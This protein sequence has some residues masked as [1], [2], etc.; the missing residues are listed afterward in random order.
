[1]LICY[2]T[3]PFELLLMTYVIFPAMVDNLINKTLSWEDEKKSHFLYDGVS[4]DVPYN[5]SGCV[6][7][8]QAFLS[9]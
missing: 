1:M 9:R 2:F 6:F 3:P 7:Y 4:F 8:L 5:Y